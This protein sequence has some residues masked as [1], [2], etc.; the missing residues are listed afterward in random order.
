[1][2]S[3][4]PSVG[5]ARLLANPTIEEKSYLGIMPGK[6]RSGGVSS[7]SATVIHDGL[8]LDL[9]GEEGCLAKIPE[10]TYIRQRNV[11]VAWEYTEDEMV[12][13]SESV[14]FLVIASSMVGVF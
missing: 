2:G 8:C 12:L 3:Q 14:W 13:R 4:N 6:I 11:N 9:E 10:M 5:L 7:P 1:M